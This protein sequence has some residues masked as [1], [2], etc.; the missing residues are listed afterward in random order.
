MAS[1]LLAEAVETGESAEQGSEGMKLFEQ[2]S[3]SSAESQGVNYE[4]IGKLISLGV[5]IN[6]LIRNEKKGSEE[7]EE[8]K[9]KRFSLGIVYPSESR[10]DLIRKGLI[11]PYFSKSA[12]RSL[13]QDMKLP[14][15]WSV[16]TTVN[17]GFGKE[18]QSMMFKK[19]MDKQSSELV[20]RLRR[21][22]ELRQALN[23]FE[24]IRKKLR[25]HKFLEYSAANIV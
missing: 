24:D 8:R 11:P 23:S 5:A 1:V 25:L 18:I 19:S 6:D 17:Q 16:E 22:K 20:E 10:D 9:N 12:I 13:I 2:D 14:Y 15:G 4:G 7:T 21:E 3:K